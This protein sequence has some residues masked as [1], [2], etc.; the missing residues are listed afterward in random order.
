MKN[1][2]LAIVLVLVVVVIAASGC[3]AKDP[4]VGKW[5]YNGA[6]YS[7]NVEFTNNS[8]MIVDELYGDSWLRFKSVYTVN[9]EKIIQTDG[10]FYYSEDEKDETVDEMEKEYSIDGDI[11]TI[12]GQDFTKVDKFTIENKTDYKNNV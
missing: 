4:L 1:K 5:E 10:T 8:K 2:I 7:S 11:L 6:I 3:A 12:N 9:N